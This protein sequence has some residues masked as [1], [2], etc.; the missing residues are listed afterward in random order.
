MFPVPFSSAILTIQRSGRVARKA[1]GK[2]CGIVIDVLDKALVK[3]KSLWSKRK[4]LIHKTF[5]VMESIKL[6]NPNQMDVENVLVPKA[7]KKEEQAD[8]QMA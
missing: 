2:E 1:D 7:P 3:T 8:G 5:E 4:N 6:Q